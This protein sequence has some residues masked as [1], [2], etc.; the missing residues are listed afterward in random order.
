MCIFYEENPTLHPERVK[1]SAVFTLKDW[2]SSTKNYMRESE[3]I[4]L[5]FTVKKKKTV[6]A[7][8]SQLQFKM[9][10][11]TCRQ[12]QEGHVPG[13]SHCSLCT[14]CLR[15]FAFYIFQL[16]IVLFIIVC[17]RATCVSMDMHVPY[18]LYV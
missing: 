13:S 6:H 9:L 3:K 12:T 18:T 4:T 1:E 5:L 11:F 14:G 7:A 17:E 15:D 16:Q 2:G 8:L 10:T